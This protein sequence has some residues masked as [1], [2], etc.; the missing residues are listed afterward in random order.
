MESDR[1]I[2]MMRLDKW[3]PI[4]QAIV[5]AIENCGYIENKNSGNWQRSRKNNV[6]MSVVQLN[7]IPED[8]NN[9]TVVFINSEDPRAP[10]SDSDHDTIL[11]RTKHVIRGAIKDYEDAKEDVIEPELM[12]EPAKEPTPKPKTKPSAKQPKKKSNVPAKVETPQ[13]PAKTEDWRKGRTDAEL[14]KEIEAAENEKKTKDFIQTRGKTY[15]AGGTERPD[16]YAVQQIANREGVSLE[17][18]SAEQTDMYCQ[19]TVRAHLNGRYVD[20]VVHHDFEVEKQLFMMEMV[21]KRKELL[22][23]YDGLTP[24]FKENATVKQKTSDGWTDVPVMYFVVHSLLKKRAF[25]ARDAR[26]KA[27]SI[28]ELAVMS[29]IDW[30]D[31]EEVNM[32]YHERDMVQNS[33]E[34]EKAMRRNK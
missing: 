33:I 31:E 18:I 26:T 13:P 25:T 3:I 16:S 14:A 9:I 19:V 27:G 2:D 28:A 1:K 6:M 15:T 11:A 12:K 30:R 5:T 8:I 29:G 22:D 21:N 32:E 24:I 23:H 4:K 34:T 10:P 7:K 20:A 17:L